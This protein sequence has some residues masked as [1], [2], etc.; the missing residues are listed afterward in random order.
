[1]T[2][3]GIDFGTTSSCISYYNIFLKKVQVLANPNGDYTTP[4]NVYFSPNCNDIV[5]GSDVKTRVITDA[6]RLLGMTWEQYTKNI[7]LQR[8]FKDKDIQIVNCGGEIGVKV[9]H[10]GKMQIYKITFIVTKILEYILAFAR[11]TIQPTEFQAV[12]TVP[13]YFSNT[14]RNVLKEI[15]ESLNVDVKKI[16]NEPTAAALA[17]IYESKVSKTN[18]TI[19]VLDCG[20]GTTDISVVQIEKDD[21]DIFCEI[22]QVIGDNFLGGQDMTHNLKKN[23]TNL[24]YQACEK[25]K[26]ELSKQFECKYYL[27]AEDTIVRITRRQFEECNNSVIT[28]LKKMLQEVAMSGID[29][30]ILIGGASQTPFINYICKEIL[31]CECV[32]TLDPKQ[33]ISIGACFQGSMF[34]AP[35]T[36]DLNLTVMDVLNLSLGIATDDGLMNVI[37]SKNTLLP[38]LKVNYFTNSQDYISEISIGVYQ[39]ERRFVKDN[40]FLGH[41]VLKGLDNTLKKGQMKI[42]IE[43]NIDSNG[44]VF[45]SAKD[46][47]TEVMSSI[48]LQTKNVSQ[49]ECS[50]D[51]ILNDNTHLNSNS[52]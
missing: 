31:R 41:L 33:S 23:Y 26:I 43:F 27:E 29:K 5:V 2:V 9:Q 11:D 28:K 16:M 44:M 35:N 24:N 25:I 19:L 14:Q 12:I 39:G 17:Y 46:Y 3:F 45:V 20:G 48:I 8:Y 37:V 13:A 18:E 51:D 21:D 49:P 6:K 38:V 40:I 15:L 4:S 10:N 22:K 32:N 34:Y 30:C 50:F 52:H 36:G 42:A 7:E 1:M 47:K